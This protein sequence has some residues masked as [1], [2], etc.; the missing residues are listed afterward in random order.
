VKFTWDERKRERN[1]RKHGIDFVDAEAVF[2]GDTLTVP[3][4]H[5][6]Y[7]E[8]RF[9]SIGL[10]NAVVVV[11]AHTEQDNIIRV[12]S[13]RKATKNEEENYF[14]EVGNKLETDEGDDR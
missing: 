1:I 5:E 13:M 10:L 3:D 9:L 14:E 8:R 6:D 12:I 7:S 11:I 4:D 2:N